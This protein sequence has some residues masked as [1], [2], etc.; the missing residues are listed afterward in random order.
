[1]SF[2]GAAIGAAVGGLAGHAV[3]GGAVGMLAG[4]T[5]SDQKALAERFEKSAEVQAI[6]QQQAIKEQTRAMRAGTVTPPPPPPPAPVSAPIRQAAAGTGSAVLSPSM[7]VRSVR[8]AT[9]KRTAGQ[10]SGSGLGYGS[11]LG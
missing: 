5:V 3:I 4:K 11:R 6:R 10:R 1:M 2:I 8:S 9:R 7:L